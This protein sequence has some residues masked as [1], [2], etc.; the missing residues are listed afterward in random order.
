MKTIRAAELRIGDMIDLS[1]DAYADPEG[2]STYFECEYATVEG[3]DHET[4][5]CVAISIEGVDM[6]GFPVDH[7]V[8][9]M[10]RG[11]HWPHCTYC[12]GNGEP[13][14]AEYLAPQTEGD[15]YRWVL[16]CG[17]HYVNKDSWWSDVDPSEQPDAIRL[18][19]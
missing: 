8:R 10:R 11:E 1:G 17:A 16:C 5:E 15:G 2:T 9:L 6:F 12:E 3:I 4:A 13:A 7:P 18:I 19:V 14:S